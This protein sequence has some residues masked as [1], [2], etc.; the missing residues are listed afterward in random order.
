MPSWTY[1]WKG[2]VTWGSILSAPLATGTRPQPPCKVLE[3]K[4][5]TIQ[6]TRSRARNFTHPRCS[7]YGNLVLPL[8]TTVGAL[9]VSIGT[10]PVHQDMVTAGPALTDLVQHLEK[11]CKPAQ[12]QSQVGSDIISAPALSNQKCPVSDGWHYRLALILPRNK[13]LEV[14]GT[15][16]NILYLSPKRAGNSWWYPHDQVDCH[17]GTAISIPAS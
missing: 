14:Q 9:D 7:N 8:V 13:P 10:V 12:G 15:S 11:D 4:T 3:K 6:K 5:T 16:Q 17:T 1:R 2:H